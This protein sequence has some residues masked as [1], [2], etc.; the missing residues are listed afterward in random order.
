MNTGTPVLIL[1]K[2]RKWYVGRMNTLTDRT[3]RLDGAAFGIQGSPV[4]TKAKRQVILARGDVTALV[5]EPG[6]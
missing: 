4:P 3:I 6:S 5:I 1:T 2:N